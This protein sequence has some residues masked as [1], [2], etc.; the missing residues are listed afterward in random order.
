MTMTDGRWEQVS[1][2]RDSDLVEVVT[3]D[4]TLQLDVRYARSDN[5]VGYPVYDE[6]RVFLQRPAAEA[7]IRV[8]QALKPQGYGLVIFDGYRP[9][10]VTKLFWDVTSG[11]QRHFVANPERGSRHNRG[12]AVDLSL[13]EVA[14]GLPVPMPSDFDE[15]TERSHSHYLGG[16]ALE[17]GHR[18]LLQQTMVA[19]GFT[20]F[21]PEWWHFDY[22]DWSLYPILNL[23]FDQI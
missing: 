22:Q 17:R 23:K 4:P 3:L 16:T 18:S 11:Y 21:D 14:T 9:W 13:F 12:C 2:C 1:E 7:L 8:H 6:A 10:D 5:F 20:L 15:M 19:A